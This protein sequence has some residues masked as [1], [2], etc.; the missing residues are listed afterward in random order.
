[1]LLLGQ[2][3]TGKSACLEALGPLAQITA[4]TG[5]AAAC[6]SGAVTL[7][8]FLGIRPCKERESF[9]EYW[10]MIVNN[11]AA[12]L[13]LR[14][15]VTLVIDEVSM[16]HGRFVLLLDLLLRKARG[17]HDVPFG[18]VQM[19]LVGD[20]L[21]LPPV[22]R[23]ED[24]WKQLFAF[25]IFSLI[26]FYPRRYDLSTVFRQRDPAFLEAMEEARNGRVSAK[27]LQYL[28][29]CEKTVFPDDGI[30]PTL[31]FQRNSDVDAENNR[32]M[33]EVPDSGNTRRVLFH[34]H[35][36]FA[37]A[38]FDS[39]TRITTYTP[40]DRPYLEKEAGGR[41]NDQLDGLPAD[42]RVRT[43]EQILFRM[44]V[45]T[46][47]A[48]V[49]NGTLGLVVGWA[50]AR[51]EQGTSTLVR[52]SAE[53]VGTHV[54]KDPRGFG[55]QAVVVPVVRLARTG[56][57]FAVYPHTVVVTWSQAER[58]AAYESEKKCGIVKPYTVLLVRRL[59]FVAGWAMTVHRVQGA[60]LDRVELRVDSDRP[61][62]P[63]SY[64]VACS[65]VRAPSCLKITGRLQSNL[66]WTSYVAEKYF[67]KQAADEAF[68]KI[69]RG[70]LLHQDH[71]AHTAYA[72]W[73]Q[74]MIKAS[75]P[76]MPS[77]LLSKD[78]LRTVTQH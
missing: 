57:H 42:M 24:P 8:K 17:L 66:F 51:P 7:Y 45:D 78:S 2:A 10:S 49:A 5:A 43:N 72:N 48:Q 75:S 36:L 68:G 23:K 70:P 60:T 50:Q 28:R 27:A 26:G 55:D 41:M 69:W 31:V 44:N 12:L 1:M 16:L 19:I 54:I 63:A 11:R 59:P 6:I 22:H 18:G 25:E 37:E 13:R 21:Q 74:D 67:G 76:K 64:Y 73:T 38:R 71:P 46:Q 77:K 4:T 47:Q 61:S 15:V 14:E 39:A 65:R 33:D 20:F 35:C 3:G 32:C 40:C 30:K 53:D 9:K 58:A 34:T 62:T 52:L 29:Q 56:D